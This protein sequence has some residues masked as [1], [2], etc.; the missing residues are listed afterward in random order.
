MKAY[1]FNDGLEQLATQVRGD[2]H[3]YL[4]VRPQEFH[5]GNML[6][7][8]AYP[9]L[10]CR[11][12]A[13]QGKSVRFSF[14]VFINDWEQDALDGPNPIDYPFNVY[15]LHTTFQYMP[16]RGNRAESTVDHWEPI[17]IG[18]IKRIQRE[19]PEVTIVPVRNS[20]MKCNKRMRSAVLTTIRHPEIVAD[21][22]RKHAS[23]TLLDEP[24]VYALAV[25]PACTYVRGKTTV[26]DQQN[27]PEITHHC[28][29]CGTVTVGDYEAFDYWFYHKPLALPRI[30]HYAIDICI[31][32]SDHYNEGDHAVRQELMERYGIDVPV[33]V[34]L[35]APVLIGSDGRKMSKSKAN[36][37]SLPFTKIMQ[38]AQQHKNEAEILPLTD[39][40]GS[41]IKS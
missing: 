2:E 28:D 26:T 16:Y 1:H 10:F 36:Y 14:Y 9:L 35:Y 31:T 4:G 6:T 33:P 32:G 19:F 40:N 3:I 13:N 7:M 22:L 37:F 27:K 25:C 21:T 41:Q 29:Q 12:V 23:F 24:I 20:A 34:T 17:I 11:A 39:T 15:P 5:A 18:Q 30:Q 8:V 38:L